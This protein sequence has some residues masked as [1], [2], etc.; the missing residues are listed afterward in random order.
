MAFCFR[1]GICAIIYEY[2][3]M[4][5]GLPSLLSNACRGLFPCGCGDRGVGLA[6]RFHLVPSLGMPGA[7]P[8]LPQCAVVVWCSIGTR[9]RLYLCL[10][11]IC[12]GSRQTLG[13]IQPPIPGVPGALSLEAKRKGREADYSPPSSAEVKSAWRYVTISSIRLHGVVLS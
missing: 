7:V 2:I 12:T 10:Y 1:R 9:G 8:P 5:W 4:G 3:F 6:T 11:D 13:P